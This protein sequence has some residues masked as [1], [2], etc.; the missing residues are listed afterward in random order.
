MNAT[1][2]FALR[3]RILGAMLGT[4]CVWSAGAH[5]QDAFPKRP[6]TWVVPYA[7]GAATDVLTRRL[8]QDLS[9]DLGQPVV[10]E[11]M[12]GAGTVNAAAH[13][14]RAKSDGY[15]V[16][17]ADSATLA[18]NPALMDKLAYD[19]QSF[20]YIGM[21][22]RF[23]LVLVVHKNVPVKSVPELIAYMGQRN[24]EINY[25]SAGLG[26]PH[27]LAMELLL[28]MTA[29]KMEHVPYNGANSA[30]ADLL[31]G[32]LDM[33]FASLGAVT[34]HIKSGALRA[35]AVSG[36][37]RFPTLPDLP[38][39]SEADAKLKGFEV[40]AW[41]GMV[42]PPGLPQDVSARLAASLHKAAASP[43]V[44]A[45]FLEQG[46][47]AVASTPV[48]FKGYAQAEAKK[49][50]NLVKSRGIKRQ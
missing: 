35:I 43:A 29:G 17:T 28:D 50:S 46:I 49:W 42:A 31:G 40:Y 47:E 3:R 30:M 23:P 13:L 12:P 7:A 34:P 25:G 11:N 36:S 41:Q 8:A 2:F 45:Y 33:M 32:R 38:T 19:P 44:K 39:L 18:L 21:F 9:T 24:G 48:E 27:H 20:S 15:R 6:V 37:Q 26:S 5:A 22:A 10:I 14:A 1:P 4:A 16:M